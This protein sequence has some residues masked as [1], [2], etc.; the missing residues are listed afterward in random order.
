MRRKAERYDKLR[1]GEEVPSAES[2]IDVSPLG[3]G[4]SFRLRRWSRAHR[5]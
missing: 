2:A 5:D 3:L 4:Y 1:K